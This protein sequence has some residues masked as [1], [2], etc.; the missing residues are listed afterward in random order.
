VRNSEGAAPRI[1]LSA[2]T[3]RLVEHLHAPHDWAVVEKL[4]A[5]ECGANL[6][7]IASPT[8]DSLERLRFAVLKL[9]G[10]SMAEFERAIRIAKIDWRDVLVAAGFGNDI[11]AHQTWLRATIGR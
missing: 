3:R 4:L 8:A 2:D 1:D 10:G 7:L 6:P 5:V 9:G 11:R